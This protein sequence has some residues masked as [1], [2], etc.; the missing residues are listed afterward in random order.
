MS[1]ACLL[2]RNVFLASRRFNPLAPVR[3][4][5][6]GVTDKRSWPSRSGSGP[7]QGFQLAAKVRGQLN[8]GLEVGGLAAYAPN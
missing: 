3:G 2:V 6:D 7:I 4:L 5:Q 8:R 1:S